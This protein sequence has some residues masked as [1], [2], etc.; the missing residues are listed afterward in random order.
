MIQDFFEA[1]VEIPTI[2]VPR[3]WIWI[4]G[5]G[6]MPAAIAGTTWDAA[7]WRTQYRARKVCTLWFKDAA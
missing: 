4:P 5:T 6:W 1:A 3:L 2:T 7:Q